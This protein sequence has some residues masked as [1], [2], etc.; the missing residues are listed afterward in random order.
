M[1][2]KHRA[3]ED[4]RRLHSP[5]FLAA[6]LWHSCRGFVKQFHYHMST[7]SWQNCVRFCVLILKPLLALAILGDSTQLE[8]I[9]FVSRGPRKVGVALNWCLVLNWICF[10][11]M[12]F[13]NVN[14]PEM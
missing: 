5:Y 9:L 7:F 14:E 6:K 12:N 2:L 13:V 11:S 1:T 3:S 8:S 4:T 10:F